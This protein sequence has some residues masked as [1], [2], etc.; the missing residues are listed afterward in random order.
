MAGSS[1]TSTGSSSTRSSKGWKSTAK[2]KFDG[3][4]Y[5]AG[6]VTAIGLAVGTV[7]QPWKHFQ[8]IENVSSVS[9]KEHYVSRDEEMTKMEEKF[10][11]VEERWRNAN[12]HS[13][14]SL[15]HLYL[16]GKPGSGKTQ[17]ALG[18]ARK[19]YEE[20]W[21][22]R[23]MFSRIAVVHLDASNLDE[24]YP[25]LLE[26]LHPGIDTKHMT[27]DDMST[28]AKEELKKFDRWLLVVDNVNSPDIKFPEP[29]V[30]GRH[31]GRILL[32]TSNRNAV[33][34][35]YATEHQLGEMTIQKALQLL[36][37]TSGHEGKHDEASE[38][39]KFL[40][41]VPLSITR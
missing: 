39:V 1:E 2:E 35:N 21:F 8:P 24:S 16:T 40:G 4:L 12:L 5:I 31:V 28:K 30:V 19:F 22:H 3:L 17:L 25:K 23:Y 27:P 36:K 10:S 29:E 14:G 20:R 6:A 32:V 9:F 33:K 34:T 18:Y 38:L 37:K 26:V 13:K 15:A 41:R 7:Y 11:E